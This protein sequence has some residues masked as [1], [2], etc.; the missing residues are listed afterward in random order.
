MTY[1]LITTILER[2]IKT[3]RPLGA[4]FYQRWLYKVW[5]DFVVEWRGH[6]FHLTAY[7]TERRSKVRPYE[8]HRKVVFALGRLGLNPQEGCLAIVARRFTRGCIDEA[9]RYK[10]VYVY[11][12]RQALKRLMD[13]LRNW[14]YVRFRRLVEA[15]QARGA[16]LR[17]LRGLEVFDTYLFLRK[18]GEAL[19]AYNW[20]RSVDPLSHI[21]F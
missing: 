10:G 4:R 16:N 3:F 20:M 21:P 5:L 7:V 11:S 2:L 14:I 17:E 19:G 13:T 9:R 8:V 12:G 18:L 6:R 1:M 15:L